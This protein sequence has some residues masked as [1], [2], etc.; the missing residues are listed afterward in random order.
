MEDIQAIKE[1]TSEKEFE[2][3]DKTWSLK[4]LENYWYFKELLKSTK[5]FLGLGKGSKY[6]MLGLQLEA[7]CKLF[8]CWESCA[9]VV[10]CTHRQAIIANQGA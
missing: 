3:E 8:I 2:I 1:E 5:P 10:H 7:M 6:S 9:N 4:V